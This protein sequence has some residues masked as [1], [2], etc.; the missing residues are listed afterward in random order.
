MGVC[1]VLPCGPLCLDP[2]SACLS[3]SDL[4]VRERERENCLVVN[5]LPSAESKAPSL[6]TPDLKRCSKNVVNCEN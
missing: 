6:S 3:V 4:R 2:R 1:V 5:D